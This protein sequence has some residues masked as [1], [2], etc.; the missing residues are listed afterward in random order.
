M[1]ALSLLVDILVF[2]TIFAPRP[3]MG[4]FPLSL[5]NRNTIRH[6]DT[7]A[8]TIFQFMENI[9]SPKLSGGGSS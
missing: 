6:T 5:K 4:K 1:K 7:G 3:H 8:R 2:G 9:T